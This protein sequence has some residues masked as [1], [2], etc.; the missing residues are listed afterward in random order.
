MPIKLAGGYAGRIVNPVLCELQAFGSVLM[1]LGEALFE[2]MHYEEGT[3]LTNNLSDYNIPSFRDA[4]SEF[5]TWLVEDPLTVPFATWT[6]GEIGV[7]HMMG[8]R[9]TR[10]LAERG[11]EVPDEWRVVDEHP[12]RG[13]VIRTYQS[14][15]AETLQWL[16]EAIRRLNL[17]DVVHPWQAVVRTR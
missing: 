9:V 13:L 10:W 8:P 16:V 12:K 5:G 7:Q 3:L 1:G 2:G 15:P 11:L 14:P 6:P 17:L 4:P